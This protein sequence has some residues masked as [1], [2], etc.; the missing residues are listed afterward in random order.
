MK[1][2]R[3]PQKNIWKTGAFFGVPNN[4]QKVGAEMPYLSG[5]P[6]SQRGKITAEGAVNMAEFPLFVC[7]RL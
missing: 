4:I 5:L 1:T 6:P 7:V 3:K 2:V